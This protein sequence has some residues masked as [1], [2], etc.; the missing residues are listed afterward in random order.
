MAPRFIAISVGPRPPTAQQYRA[1][2]PPPNATVKRYQP[3]VFPRLLVHTNPLGEALQCHPGTLPALPRPFSPIPHPSSLPSFLPNPL[4]QAPTIFPSPGHETPLSACAL[5]LR[6]PN[7]E[8][9][10]KKKTDTA[11]RLDFSPP[12]L[13]AWSVE[14]LSFAQPPFPSRPNPTPK[15]A[16]PRVLRLQ[17]RPHRPALSITSEPAAAQHRPSPNRFVSSEPESPHQPWL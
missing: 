10:R 13:T 12:R 4:L 2:S 1:H 3:A 15:C 6:S 5:T 17:S 14:K 11:P 8:V 9:L 16:R 7:C